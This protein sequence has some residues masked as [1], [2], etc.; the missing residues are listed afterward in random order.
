MEDKWEQMLQAKRTPINTQAVERKGQPLA[1][2]LKVH[3]GDGTGCNGRSRAVKVMLH[4][5]H[6]R[7]STL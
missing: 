2:M 6:C 7:V 1:E 4:V 3:M 5:A